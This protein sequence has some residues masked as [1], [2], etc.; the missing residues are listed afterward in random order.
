MMD[1]QPLPVAHSESTNTPTTSPSSHWISTRMGRQQIS[2]SVVQDWL[3]SETSTSSSNFCQQK[4][5]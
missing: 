4:G 5:H 1:R 2:Q 3:P